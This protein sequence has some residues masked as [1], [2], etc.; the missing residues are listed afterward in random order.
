MEKYIVLV[1]ITGEIKQGSG[2]SGLSR[3][4]G[5]IGPFKSEEECTTWCFRFALASQAFPHQTQTQIVKLIDPSQNI[6]DI[7]VGL[8]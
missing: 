8:Q 2:V 7:I 1:T 3:N 6:G 5:I 4:H